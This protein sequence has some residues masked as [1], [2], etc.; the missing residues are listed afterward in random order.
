MPF[1]LTQGILAQTSAYSFSGTA[2][3][4][5]NSLVYWNGVSEVIVDGTTVP[6]FSLSNDAGVDFG[7]S[8]APVPEP[9]HYAVLAGLGLL[10]FAVWR[11]TRTG[12]VNA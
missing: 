8:F 5:V 9:E 7:H 10:G 11:R 2:D 3:F 6:D 12:P 1:P 4:N